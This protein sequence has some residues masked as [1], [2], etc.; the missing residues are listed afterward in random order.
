MKKLL[1]A[2]LVTVMLLPLSACKAEETVT[3][4]IPESI[5]VTP[6]D[7]VGLPAGKYVYVFE[8][9]WQTK[10]SFSA[11]LEEVLPGVDTGINAKLVYSNCTVVME[12]PGAVMMTIIYNEK[13]LLVSQTSEVTSGIT[14]LRMETTCTYDARG[15]KLSEE[16]KTSYE[17][18]DKPAVTRTSYTYTETDTG[19]EG[20]SEAGYMTTVLTY[21]KN[22]RLICTVST[23]SGAEVAR[24]ENTYDEVGNLIL[25]QTF[26]EGKLVTKNERTYREVK[27][28]R[29]TADRLP[30]F[31]R[32]N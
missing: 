25:T 16:T 2:F 21:D 15:R 8:E 18:Q 22:D 7:E 28:S 20:R 6:G 24:I 29:E 32:G 12:Q 23:V 26:A 10:E 13:G 19:S 27:V 31:K 30:N 14:L 1:C 3:I 9:G 5:T 17:D 4:Y 11:T